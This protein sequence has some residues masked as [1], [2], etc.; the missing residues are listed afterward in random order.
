MSLKI[1]PVMK[2]VACFR[3]DP[4]PE[5]SPPRSA[6]FPSCS[7]SPNLHVPASSHPSFYSSHSPMLTCISRWSTR[8]P[9]WKT[10]AKQSIRLRNSQRQRQPLHQH[11]TASQARLQTP[12]PMRTMVIA[13]QT[14]TTAAS[15]RTTSRTPDSDL[16]EKVDVTTASGIR[17]A[18]WDVPSNC[19]SLHLHK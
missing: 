12:P 13:N 5:R 4:S 2:V 18:I 6:E 3:A 7:C 10:L 14:M 11:S 16:E 17:K 8:R 19:T 15:A 1:R 9:L